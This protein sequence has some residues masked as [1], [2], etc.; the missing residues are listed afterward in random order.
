MWV[1]CQ[2][3]GG[4]SLHG[5]QDA[6]RSR[7]GRG[8]PGHRAAL[9]TQCDPSEQADSKEREARLL[10]EE[11]ARPLRARCRELRGRE[12][13]GPGLGTGP[14]GGTQTQRSAACLKAVSLSFG[15]EGMGGPTKGAA[16]KDRQGSAWD[17][18]RQV[19][20]AR[21][22]GEGEG[23]SRLSPPSSRPLEPGVRA[24]AGSGHGFRG[25]PEPG[26]SWPCLPVARAHC[27]LLSQ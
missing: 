19:Q 27:T 6:G 4:C 23:C 22:G 14:V 12:T 25:S 20:A 16:G 18:P 5:S 2:A 21:G 3:Q 1:K 13:V 11:E 17:R 15:K 24:A 10:T 26:H 7:G 8:Q 9:H